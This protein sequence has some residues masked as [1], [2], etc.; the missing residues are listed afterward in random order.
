M[1]CL[2][3]L[4]RSKLVHH[5]ASK[6]D[7][8]RLTTLGFD[9]LALRALVLAGHVSAVGRQIGVG[10]ESDVYEVMLEDGTSAALKLH[11][12]GRT[13]FR[14]V[15]SKRDYIGA[16]TAY[17]WLTLSRLAATKEAAFMKALHAAAFPT[18]ALVAHNRHAVLMTLVDGAPLHRARARDVPDPAS[19]YDQAVGFM[20]GL[21]A[22]GL[23]HCDLN[24]FNL[25]LTPDATSLVL[26]DFPQMVSTGHANA[27]ELFDRDAA[28]LAR[29]F[30][31]KLGYDP[32]ADPARSASPLASFDAGVAA[33]GPLGDDGGRAARKGARRAA[34][35][36]A[37]A[38][39]ALPDD[40]VADLGATL[41][42]SGFRNKDAAA[43]EACL[44]GMRVG[45]EGEEEDD[46][47]SSSDEGSER[48]RAGS[49]PAEDAAPAPAPPAPASALDR[50]AQVAARVAAEARAAARG[51]LTGGAA[52]GAARATAKSRRRGTRAGAAAD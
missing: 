21:A 11:R 25:I 26:I 43:L 27:R 47:A 2:S 30:S 22:R 40:G 48:D 46:G 15:A 7:G 6:Y 16:R 1:R 38:G 39:V 17:S 19:L 41:A 35:A 23:V 50:S 31:S 8:Y 13:S 34:S 49:P 20:E 45:G 18:P 51:R 32:R 29:F 5:D 28:V 24:E 12:L 3:T 14:A 52:R 42:A 36:A 4:L 44:A 9:F 33:A 10:K 37:R